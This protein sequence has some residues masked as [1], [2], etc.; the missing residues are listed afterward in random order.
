M[1][2]VSGVWL[3]CVVVYDGE[4]KQVRSTNR[5]EYRQYGTQRRSTEYGPRA[6]TIVDVLS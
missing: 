4:R 5:R 6:Q 3:L 2:V 1:F